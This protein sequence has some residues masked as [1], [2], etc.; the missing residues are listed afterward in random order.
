MI[1][2]NY[3]CVSYVS[4]KCLFVGFWLWCD[5]IVVSGWKQ[6]Q[7]L[8]FWLKTW[9]DFDDMHIVISVIHTQ[10]M[11]EK[12]IQ[13]NFV[14]YV[15]DILDVK[16]FKARLLNVAQKSVLKINQFEVDLQSK[17]SSIFT[18][19]ETFQERQVV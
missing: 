17:L 5:V 18:N 12:V 1:T 7:L 11:S 8:V 4:C 3:G 13:I 16:N 14:K 9:L 19:S 15:K 6:S 10:Y 2:D